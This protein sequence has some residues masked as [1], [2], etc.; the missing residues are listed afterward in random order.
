MLQINS[1]QSIVKQPSA[2][3]SGAILP[4]CLRPLVPPKIIDP[5]YLAV[6]LL[7][8]ALQQQVSVSK[9]MQPYNDSAPSG[10]SAGLR[11]VRYAVQY[12]PQR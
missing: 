5:N 11:H 8:I 3:I 7:S 9:T 6:S 1:H 4:D 12:K 10:D 2:F